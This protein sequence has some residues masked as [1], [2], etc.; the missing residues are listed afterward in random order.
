MGCES[1]TF[2]KLPNVTTIEKNTFYNCIRLVKFEVP[3]TVTEIDNKAFFECRKLANIKIPNSVT[4]IG[5]SVFENC[6]TITQIT[7]PESVTSIG[8]FVFVN[9]KNLV[10]INMPK[11]LVDGNQRDMIQGC[12]NLSPATKFRFCVPKIV[13]GYDELTPHNSKLFTTPETPISDFEK[14]SNGD[15]NYI[16]YWGSDS[17]VSIPSLVGRGVVYNEKGYDDNSYF[18]SIFEHPSK[19]L[20][21]YIPDSVTFIGKYA[22]GRCTSLTQIYIPDSVTNIDSDAF[23]GC[24]NLSQEAKNKILSINSNAKF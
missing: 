5:N 19:I 9:C 7:I 13:Q 6:T 11:A 22:F 23:I 21:V 16:K 18:N 3:E 24:S 14:I 12:D 15:V 2:I 8:G 4:T 10:K 20:E 17:I 1:L